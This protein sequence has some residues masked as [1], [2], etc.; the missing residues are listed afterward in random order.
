MHKPC[1][2]SKTTDVN[3]WAG[4]FDVIFVIKCIGFFDKRSATFFSTQW[5]TNSKW[6]SKAASSTE[7]RSL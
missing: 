6:K 2:Q 5:A 4:L 7:T 3:S 1:A